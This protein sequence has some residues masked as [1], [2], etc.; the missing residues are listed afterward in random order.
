MSVLFREEQNNKV[1]MCFEGVSLTF[2]DIEVAFSEN[3]KI[4]GFV[5]IVTIFV[6]NFSA[7]V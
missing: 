5:Y 1:L 2:P 6:S 7:L 4:Y 3:N